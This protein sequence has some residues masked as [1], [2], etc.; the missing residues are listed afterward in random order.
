MGKLIVMMTVL[1][2]VVLGAVELTDEEKHLLERTAAEYWGDVYPPEIPRAF[3]VHRNGCPVC[4]EAIKKYGRYAWIIDPKKPFKLQCPSCKNVFPDNDFEAYWKSG[5]KDK[6]LLKGK[7]VDDGRGWSPGEGQPKYWFVAYYNHWNIYMPESV[8]H[9]GLAYKR[10]KD[11]R[12]A[13]RALAILDHF[14]DYYPDYDYNKQSRYAEE[15]DHNYTGRF[16]N[17]C[18][19][20]SL[21]TDHLADA[22]LNTREL[23]KDEIAELTQITGKSSAQ[24]KENIENRLFKT[25]ANDIV[26]INGRNEGNFGMHQKALLKISIILNDI[27]LAKWCTDFRVCWSLHSMPLDYA[28]YNNI[29]SDGAPL[30]APGYNSLWVENIV[31]MFDLLKTGGIDEFAA[32]PSTEHIFYYGAKMLVCGKFTP[33]T[34][35][36]GMTNNL[37]CVRSSKLGNEFLYKLNPTPFNARMLLFSVGKGSELY[38]KLSKEADMDFGY[39]SNLLSAYGFASLQN[40][41][42]QTPTAFVLTFPNYSCHSHADR[43][44]IDFFA[45]NAPMCPDF[46]YPDSASGDDIERGAF[47]CNT[48]THNTVTVNEGT[49]GTFGSKLMRY[50]AGDF[51][52]YVS[53]AA[54]G[55]Y[56]ID[57]YARSSL[58]CEVAPGKMVILDV[59]RVAGGSKH[60]WFLHSA[61]EVFDTDIK[62]VDQDGK[63][64]ISAKKKLYS[65]NAN[66][67]YQFLSNVKYGTGHYGNCI[68]LP[69]DSRMRFDDNVFANSQS[70][71]VNISDNSDNNDDN[72]GGPVSGAALK[73]HL[74]NDGEDVYVSEGKSP[75]TH[76]NPFKHV[77]F[78]TRRRTGTNLNSVFG[79]VLENTSDER[80]AYD[81]VSI[82]SIDAGKDTCAALIKLKDGKLLYAF[83]SEKIA[84]F[85]A[86]GIH[87]I[88]EAGA[89][90]IDKANGI[91]KAF[92]TGPGSIE[93]NGKVVVKA[94]DVWKTQAT[95][96]FLAEDSIEFEN[97]VPLKYLGK[98]FKL[99]DKAYQV[100]NIYGNKIR[101]L[102]QGMILGRARIVQYAS[103]DKKAG[104]MMPI[105]ELATAGMGLYKGDAKDQ[106]VGIIK[107]Y[108]RGNISVDSESALEQDVDYWI[109]ECNPGD[110]AVFFDCAR[111]TFKLVPD[112]Q[113]EHK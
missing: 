109:S 32:H 92:V 26:T 17:G 91:G 96:L 19:W 66:S 59:F 106:Y 6:S 82:S 37:G 48:V 81:I 15:V 111:S 78:L 12:F 4:G 60:D 39:A 56:G 41:N 63:K 34:G 87:F 14:G 99:G 93:V 54:P 28:I 35:D 101:L 46:G 29:Y 42:K 100:G 50:E 68:T 83:N 13:I 49:Q 10:T 80:K 94:D 31:E 24:I 74:L 85:T 57:K 22:Y 16:L 40:G 64:G 65:G 1:L 21:F 62:L 5:F 61:G 18:S 11:P 86:D 110:V 20:E 84:D 2:A 47:Y 7:Y 73:V 53:A 90:L 33:S 52:Q 104:L 3:D 51:A 108:N 79:T 105:P 95:K 71:Y 44:H 69:V 55:V 36:S 112:E 45:E 25:V 70:S 102:E 97:E 75:R 72:K 30:E 38:E 76:G 58:V 8:Y 77:V 103:D 89:L 98:M 107:S 67:G 43:L 9:L 113:E 88:G 27:N 23:L